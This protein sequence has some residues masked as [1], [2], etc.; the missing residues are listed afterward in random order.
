MLIKAIRYFIVLLLSVFIPLTLCQAANHCVRDSGTGDGTAWNNAL[1]DLPATLVRDDVYYIADGDY[2]GYGVNDAV[3]GTKVVYI[4]KATESA[5]GT[6][7]G[8]S[9]AYGDGQATFPAASITTSYVEWDGVTGSGSDSS[10]YGFTI[11]PPVP[12]T[13][14]AGI[15][16]GRYTLMGVGTYG[17]SYSNVIISHTAFFGCGDPVNADQAR[18]ISSNPTAMTNAQITYNYFIDSANP[19]LMR[20]WSSSTISDNYFAGNVSGAGANEHGQQISAGN[21]SEIT[22]KDNVFK[23]SLVYLVGYHRGAGHGPWYVYN[24]LIIGGWFVGGWANADPGTDADRKD[25]L[26]GWRVY[27]NTFVD[28]LIGGYGFFYDDYSSGNAR[29]L[30]NNL[31][32][33]CTGAAGVDVPGSVTDD[34]NYYNSCTHVPSAAN[35]VTSTQTSVQ[36]F[37]DYD[38]DDFQLVAGSEAI[39]EGI[40]LGATYNADYDEVARPQDTLWDIGAYEFTG[41]AVPS[42]TI[43]VAGGIIESD[44]VTGSKTLVLTLDGTTWDADIG[45]AGDETTALIAG[46]DSDKAE[47]GGWDAK[48]KA[49]LAHGDITRT[50]ATVVTIILPAI[51]DYEITASETVT[52]T[53]DATCVASATEIVAEP[54]F[55]ISVD[56]LPDVTG[57]GA[58]ITA[59]G[60]A[61]TKTANGLAITSP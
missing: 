4:Y 22:L 37:V 48:V 38:G 3:D 53:I 18:S 35:N 56:T 13:C 8:W 61:A 11:G 24:N 23:D 19:I 33:N 29:Y 45:D 47:A 32:Y 50:S 10:S 39:N 7:T 20:N 31:F 40:D 34:Y 60:L 42:G 46:I 43:V 30:K 41:A 55:I 6:D 15:P 16:D 17:T 49:V 54:T 44:I 57:V 1:D 25:L 28:M 36:T 2:A 52:V 21:C 58:Y 5:H 9:S 59:N 14:A 27:N 26:E 51:A 12:A